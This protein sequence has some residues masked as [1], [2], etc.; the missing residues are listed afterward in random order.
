M[1]DNNIIHTVLNNIIKQ[2]FRDTNLTQIGKAPRYFDLS[3][4]FNLDDEIISCPG[5]RAAASNSMYGLTLVI[6]NVNKFMTTQSCLDRI[7]EIED[8]RQVKDK[9]QRVIDEFKGQSVIGDWG[10]MRAYIVRDVLFEK[11][12]FNMFFVT[13]NNQRLN[14]AEYFLKAYEKKITEKTQPLFVVRHNG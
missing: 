7:W 2:A 14:I 8:N 1:E 10:H 4:K 5:F 13:P 3:K 12:P 11:N 9:K 6:D